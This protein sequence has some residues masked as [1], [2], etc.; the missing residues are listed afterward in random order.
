MPNVSAPDYLFQTVISVCGGHTDRSRLTGRTTDNGVGKRPQEGLI[1]L[2]DIDSFTG[3]FCAVL[4]RRLYMEG[5]RSH[6]V[7]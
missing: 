2:D 6:G 3:A 5:Q 7:A 1:L 4:S